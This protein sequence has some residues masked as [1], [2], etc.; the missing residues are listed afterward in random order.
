[1]KGV[2]RNFAKFKGKHLCQSLFLN[3]VAG[4]NFIKKETMAQVISFEFCKISEAY[5]FI[6]K[7]SDTGVFL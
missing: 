2:L 4:R 3:K 6:K 1:M 7:D 5:N